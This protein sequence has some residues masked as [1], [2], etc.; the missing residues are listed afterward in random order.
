MKMSPVES[1][2]SDEFLPG[3]ILK[4]FESVFYSMNKDRFCRTIAEVAFID[5]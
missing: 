1:E 4:I 5:T 3:K 2:S